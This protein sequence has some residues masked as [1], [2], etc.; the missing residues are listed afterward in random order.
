MPGDGHVGGVGV[1]FIKST[2]PAFCLMVLRCLR[3]KEVLLWAYLI[4][5]VQPHEKVIFPFFYHGIGED[6]PDYLD[7]I[8]AATQQLRS[9]MDM[10][11]T[12]AIEIWCVIRRNSSGTSAAFRNESLRMRVG[13]ACELS[14]FNDTRE[15]RRRRC[16]MRMER[17]QSGNLDFIYPRQV[18]DCFDRLSFMASS[19]VL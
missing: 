4:N 3:R 13:G 6:S 14:S 5:N 8:P 7:T 11:C 12:S 1:G 16:G 10:W 19:C 15:L 9:G 17:C 18:G 2:L